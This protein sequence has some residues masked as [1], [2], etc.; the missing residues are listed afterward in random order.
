MA[1]L[2]ALESEAEHLFH[3]FIKTH[4][5]KDRNA[6]IQ[7]TSSLTLMHLDDNCRRCRTQSVGNPCESGCLDMKPSEEVEKLNADKPR[8]SERKS[9]K[10]VCVQKL[11]YSFSESDDNDVNGNAI[12]ESVKDGSVGSDTDDDQEESGGESDDEVFTNRGVGKPAFIEIEDEV[13]VQ[14]EVEVLSSDASPVVTKKKQVFRTISSG[15]DVS[16]SGRESEDS[17][18][19]LKE[20]V[21]E[22]TLNL[23]SSKDF[24]EVPEKKEVAVIESSSGDDDNYNNFITKCNQ[25]KTCNVR[26]IDISSDDSEDFA[27]PLRTKTSNLLTPKTGFYT[28]HT[29]K[30]PKSVLKTP[31][32]SLGNILHKF[33]AM[34]PRT[35]KYKS[36]FNKQRDELIKEL[37]L[38]YNRTVFDRKL[39]SD[40]KITWNKRMT[41]TAGF[42]YLKTTTFGRVSHV[43]LSTKVVDSVERLRDTLIHELCHA[44]T[45]IFE[46]KRGHGLAWKYWAKKANK[47]HPELPIIATCHT[48]DI[49][50]KF[51]YQCDGCGVVF[52]RHTKS[53]DATKHA[54]AKCGGRPL[55]LSV[56]GSSVSDTPKKTNAYSE[57]VKK[58]YSRVKGDNPDS[59]SRDIMKLVAEDFRA[60]KI[61]QSDDKENDPTL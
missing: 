18:T 20:R 22:K 56:S 19:S 57:Y 45:W 53:I 43:E 9:R 24:H 59:S 46:G 12:D 50:T 13:R 31:R 61:S 60:F 38:L 26:S 58:H 15:S 44:A 36:H 1:S 54:C 34:E 35:P 2:E 48:Y 29:S 39:P 40:F 11:T 10:S 41:K 28:P 25:P 14:D 17:G 8:K 27:T 23:S 51:K 4:Q 6:F 37:F 16:T 5:F 42:C 33:P 32:S 3:N 30:T 49:E 47:V 7:Y 52:G 21:V 55:L